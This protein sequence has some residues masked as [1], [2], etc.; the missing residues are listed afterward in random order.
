MGL[1]Q[2]LRNERFIQ[3]IQRAGIQDFGRDPIGFQ[4]FG[5]CQSFVNHL[6]RCNNG[7][8]LPSTLDVALSQGDRGQAVHIPLHRIDGL[9]LKEHD[10]VV[11]VNGG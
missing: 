11:I 10:R 5:S 3:R 7:H 1:A 4:H 8:I 6:A 9:V 2:G